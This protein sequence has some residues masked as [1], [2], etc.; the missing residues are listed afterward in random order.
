[1]KLP[2]KEFTNLM[3]PGQSP[4]KAL[5][6]SFSRETTY[7]QESS[8]SLRYKAGNTPMDANIY[9]VKSS[10][11][12]VLGYE[13]RVS[14]RDILS[15]C[16]QM[17]YTDDGIEYKGHITPVE[18]TKNDVS[19]YCTEIHDSYIKNITTMRI[20]KIV[21][22]PKSSTKIRVADYRTTAENYQREIQKFEEDNLPVLFG[23]SS[24]IHPIIYLEALETFKSKTKKFTSRIQ[25]LYSSVDSSLAHVS[26]EQQL[27]STDFIEGSKIVSK[28]IKRPNR[29]NRKDH[30][31]NKMKGWLKDKKRLALAKT[32]KLKDLIEQNQISEVIDISVLTSFHVDVTV[33]HEVDPVVLK[34]SCNHLWNADKNE[35]LKFYSKKV[36]YVIE[37]PLYPSRSVIYRCNDINVRQMPLVNNNGC[38]STE[39]NVEIGREFHHYVTIWNGNLQFLLDTDKDKYHYVSLEGVSKIPIFLGD[40]NGIMCFMYHDHPVML[41][42]QNKSSLD[43]VP[44]T[45]TTNGQLITQELVER[46]MME[47][48]DS[49]RI[50]D[51]LNRY[52]TD[53]DFND[54]IDLTQKRLDAMGKIKEESKMEV[55][56]GDFS[57]NSDEEQSIFD[58][59]DLLNRGVRQQISASSDQ[60]SLTGSHMSRMTNQSETD[61]SELSHYRNDNYG[62]EDYMPE[63]TIATTIDN[64]MYPSSEIVNII[65]NEKF[66]APQ[67]PLLGMSRALVKRQGYR[68][69]EY[70]FGIKLF[71]DMPLEIK[72]SFHKDDEIILHMLDAAERH[73]GQSHRYKFF[74]AY[75]L[76]ALVNTFGMSLIVQYRKQIRQKNQ[77]DESRSLDSISI[78]S[79]LD[80][81]VAKM[82]ADYV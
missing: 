80:E 21:P 24:E 29:N 75:L 46:H 9:Y 25:K 81:D 56:N 6:S 70:T 37:R 67:G 8:S 3:Y 17:K 18:K 4:L 40:L 52:T 36:Q 64:S 5:I 33:G 82:W 13:T 32:L 74:K 61:D 76:S 45:I 55:D 58:M 77:L 19:E 59:I 38:R 53:I 47:D 50:L 62:D 12:S 79:E 30:Y 71:P 22:H 48:V 41:L 51:D 69:Y 26:I 16:S 15:F 54:D 23:G 78:N 42:D 66:H 72:Q 2:E 28:E 31:L 68:P 14:R 63:D 7:Y 10:Y 57:V 27:L 1:M 34:E 49:R 43:A 20:D 73:Y 44:T 65:R 35:N 11:F 39:I 60:S